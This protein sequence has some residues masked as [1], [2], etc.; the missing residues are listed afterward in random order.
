M[1]YGKALD[2]GQGFWHNK[3]K[4]NTKIDYF[5]LHS[6]KSLIN[7][8]NAYIKTVIS[9]GGRKINSRCSC[10]VKENG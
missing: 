3:K 5:F 7:A 1:N 2:R 6:L 10:G 4:L 9:Q 8:I